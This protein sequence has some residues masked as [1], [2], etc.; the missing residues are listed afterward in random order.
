MI[1]FAYTGTHGSSSDPPMADAHVVNN[2]Q[3]GMQ[4]YV[5]N[6]C[7][8]PTLP[9]YLTGGD[10]I[11][12]FLRDADDNTSTDLYQFSTNKYCYFYQLIDAANQMPN[13]QNNP[14]YNWTKLADTIVINGRTHNIYKSRLMAPGEYGYFAS[15]G[16][17][18]TLA[19]SSNL[20]CGICG[21]RGTC[22]YKTRT[23]CNS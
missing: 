18:I 16:Y 1:D 14:N 10:Y 2:A 21:I 23:N 11:Q 4:V 12:A 19:P 22:K 6:S 15:N 9:S 5:D 13:H 20:Y 3:A 17:G 8:F 7:T